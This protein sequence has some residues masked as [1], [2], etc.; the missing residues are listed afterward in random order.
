LQ[1]NFLVFGLTKDG[2][3]D[4]LSN[5][6]LIDLMGNNISSIGLRVFAADANLT[7]LRYVKLQSNSL[8]ELE[9]WPMIR[10]QLVPGTQIDLSS[11]EV[12]TFSNRLGW[13]F[14]CGTRPPVVATINLKDNLMRHATDLTNG[15]NIE[16]E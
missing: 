12:T 3:F 10:G 14:K 8:K 13:H 6:E 9:P 1:W 4:G 2:L 16:S 7:H 11:N 15:W 5:L